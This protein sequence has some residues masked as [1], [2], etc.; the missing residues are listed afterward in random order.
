M[1]RKVTDISN[2]VDSY[3]MLS[4]TPENYNKD[5]FYL[6]ELQDK[7]DAEWNYRF[8]RVE[9][10]FERIGELFWGHNKYD[11]IEVVQQHVKSDTATAY[12]DDYRRLVFRD[13]REQRFNIGHKF[14]FMANNSKFVSGKIQDPD[15][16]VDDWYDKNDPRDI[17]LVTN[18]SSVKASTSVIVTRCN[19]VLGSL[20]L[21]E[22]KVAHR[23]YE[24]IIRQIDLT[25]TNL[26]FNETAVSPQNS[27]V[28]IVQH[29]DFTKN[30]Y[31][32][33]RFII[34]YD[35][36][37]RIKAI[38][39][40][41]GKNTNNPK[42]VGLMK[43]Y[44]EVTESSTYDDFD[45]LIAYQSQPEIQIDTKGD[46]NYSIKII[47]PE[48]FP[49]DLTFN[50]IDFEAYLYQNEQA[51]EKDIQVALTLENLPAGVDISRYV[52]YEFEEGSGNCFTLTK[53]RM[54]PMGD[55]YVKIYVDQEHSPTGKELSCSFKLAVR[56]VN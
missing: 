56:G 2:D 41:Y 19:G 24:P 35:Q 53:H 55:L 7:F 36:V 10:E 42:N 34:G 39:K 38:D 9:V 1:A 32:N 4:Q 40:F 49:T 17:W 5:N 6:K 48:E 3:S 26:F 20:C 13:I 51:I 52:T 45:N 44:F 12:T 28:G 50:N 8:N 43:I 21:D 23:H 11:K 46:D 16:K 37:Y 54:Y 33:Q 22:Q 47:K 18:F 31:I 25:A 15:P 14:R 30:Y 29:N 27:F